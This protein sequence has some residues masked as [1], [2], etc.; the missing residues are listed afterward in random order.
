[1]HAIFSFLEGEQHN[2]TKAEHH[3]DA[4]VGPARLIIDVECKQSD[5]EGVRLKDDHLQSV[6]NQDEADVDQEKFSLARQHSEEHSGVQLLGHLILTIRVQHG[7]AAILF[8]FEQE[9]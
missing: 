9:R 3:R 4:L 1:M 8:G 2:S 7:D 5:P 6:G